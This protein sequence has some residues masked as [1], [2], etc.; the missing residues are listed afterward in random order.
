MRI[1]CA[2]LTGIPGRKRILHPRF[3]TA[4]CRFFRF[5]QTSGAKSSTV[6]D[7]ALRSLGNKQAIF[8]QRQVQ[9]ARAV[10]HLAYYFVKVRCLPVVGRCL[11]ILIR[12]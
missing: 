2:Q 11:F 10:A 3:Y 4:L 8:C 9:G 7:S 1:M 5:E 6:Q 12:G